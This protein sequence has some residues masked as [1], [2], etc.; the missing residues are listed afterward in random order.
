MWP[1][2]DT[3]FVVMLERLVAHSNE[4]DLT[5]LFQVKQ[6]LSGFVLICNRMCWPNAVCF[7]VMKKNDGAKPLPT[8]K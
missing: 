2:Q 5:L 1:K 4:H 8:A 3:F 7:A 6:R